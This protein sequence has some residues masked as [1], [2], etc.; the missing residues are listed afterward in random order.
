MFSLGSASHAV[1]IT[2]IYP[3]RYGFST[4]HEDLAIRASKGDPWKY[5]EMLRKIY[6]KPDVAFSVKFKTEVQ[7]SN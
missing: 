5:S 7:V 2:E 1:P 6:V 3:G 4:S